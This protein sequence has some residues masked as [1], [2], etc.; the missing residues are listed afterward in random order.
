[1]SVMSKIEI[2]CPDCRGTGLYRGIFE[3]EGFAVVCRGCNGTA[4]K[5]VEYTQFTG[6]M[7]RDDVKTVCWSRGFTTEIR[8][9][10]E[11][12]PYEDFLVGK[13]PPSQTWT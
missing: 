9:E 12:I 5:V 13:L 2:Q 6:R 7:T 3:P 10:S 8:K 4:K 11:G 1:M